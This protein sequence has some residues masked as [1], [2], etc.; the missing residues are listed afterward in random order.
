MVREWLGAAG[1]ITA[2]SNKHPHGSKSKIVTDAGTH[3]PDVVVVIEDTSQILESLQGLV[4]GQGVMVHATFSPVEG[5]KSYETPW[6]GIRLLVLDS[7]AQTLRD[8]EV[9]EYLQRV[10]PRIRVVFVSGRGGDA[11]Q[12]VLHNR[13]RGFSQRALVS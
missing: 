12:E 2:M 10:N 13:L 7:L 1:L 4:E 3:G 5:M 6:H 11:A 9:V 8:D